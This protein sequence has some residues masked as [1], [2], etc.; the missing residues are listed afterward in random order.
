M[1]SNYLHNYTRVFVISFI[2]L[3]ARVAFDNCQD[4]HR[5]TP[6]KF[7]KTYIGA[8]QS[9]ACR[10]IVPWST[11][12]HPWRERIRQAPYTTRW[13]SGRDREGNPALYGGCECIWR[14]WSSVNTYPFKMTGIIYGKI[15]FLTGQKSDR[16]CNSIGKTT[17][18]IHP[19][20]FNVTASFAFIF[21]KP[22]VIIFTDGYVVVKWI[23]HRFL[24]FPLKVPRFNR[25]ESFCCL[26]SEFFL[27]L[28]LVS[29]SLNTGFFI[30]SNSGIGNR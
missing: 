5:F 4:R 29:C 9:P 27:P 2:S 23:A 17:R 25:R 28:K 21:K 6:E 22:S 15:S 14:A 30:E 19:N 20:G 12:H 18:I 24:L 11:D 26:R 3:S 16:R 1:L 7:V 13:A 8:D 10:T